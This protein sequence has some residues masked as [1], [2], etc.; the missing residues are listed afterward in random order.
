MPFSYSKNAGLALENL[1]Q[2]LRRNNQPEA[3]TA[4][5]VKAGGVG[6]YYEV[7]QTD[8]PDSGIK[9][10]IY[11]YSSP[12]SERARRFG[13]FRI[14]GEGYIHTFPGSTVE[15]QRDAAQAAINGQSMRFG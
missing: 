12:T 7:N 1:M 14:D 15:Q 2:I 11:K 6:Y 13:S 4:W 8:Q 5:W 3:P 9:G 10:S